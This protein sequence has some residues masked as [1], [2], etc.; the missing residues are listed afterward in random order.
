MFNSSTNTIGGALY[1]AFSTTIATFM[2]FL[3][4]LIAAIVVFIIGLF[5]SR[6]VRKIVVGVLQAINL[7]QFVK[8]SQLEKVLKQ[9]QVKLHPE[10][11]I[12]A[13]V[14]WL[15]II[16][17]FITA[18]NIVGL[19][20]VSSFLTSLVAYLPQVFAALLIFI[21]GILAAG[22]V[23][24]IIKSTT[25]SM[26]HATSRLLAKAGSYVVMI[27][28]TLVAISELGIA[29]PFIQALFYGFVATIALALGLSFGL[30]AKDIANEILSDWYKNL[31]KRQKN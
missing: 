1:A 3:P 14:E 21:V 13:A 9:A 28:T 23:E 31:K 18:V 11:A 25:A 2:A 29:Q 19:T 8:D 7:S 6:W 20:T 26:E 12:G 17:F 22:F 4:Q 24:N 16:V 10:E 15:I 5:I 27:F 30:G